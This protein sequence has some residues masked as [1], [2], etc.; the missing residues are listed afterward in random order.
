MFCVLQYGNLSK[1]TRSQAPTDDHCYTV[2]TYIPSSYRANKDNA[3]NDLEQP[4][5]MEP[6]RVEA[7]LLDNDEKIISRD[8]T[9]VLNV[10]VTSSCHE[11]RIHSLHREHQNS[12][13]ENQQKYMK[14]LESRIRELETTEKAVKSVFRAD[15]IRNM[16]LKGQFT[17]R[18]IQN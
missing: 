3:D 7:V 5:K 15:Q 1:L 13:I 12:V 11:C 8:F 16:G 18:I 17:P 14:T 2:R 10:E 9:D 6:G 4:V